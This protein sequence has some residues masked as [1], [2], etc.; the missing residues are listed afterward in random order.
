MSAF[1]KIQVGLDLATSATIVLAGL[2][3]YANKRRERKIGILNDARATVVEN[4]NA[5]IN[6]M[7]LEFNSFATAIISVESTIDRHLQRGE[8]HYKKAIAEKKIDIESIVQSFSKGVNDIGEFFEKASTLR[9]TIFPSLYSI[10]NQKDAVALLKSELNDVLCVYNESNAGYISL[11]AELKNLSEIIQS[12]KSQSDNQD[13]EELFKLVDAEY[14]KSIMSILL[15][16][17]YL[18]FIDAFIPK[19]FEQDYLQ[20]LDFSA[21]RNEDDI[22]K[23]NKLF[24]RV[25]SRFLMTIIDEPEETLAIYLNVL[26]R[27][28]LKARMQCKEL[29]VC[30]SAISCKMQQKS[31]NLSIREIYRDLSSN[32][33]LST[34]TEIR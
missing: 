16:R 17:D 19:G 8:E 34:E 27:Q 15:D 6:T 32:D 21:N 30:L 23:V 3:W 7:S 1:E 5:S 10:G 13:T 24:S 22:Q 20:A 12:I 28:M 14:E 4:I 2:T 26:S 18:F 33:Y 25:Y 11:Y 29:L 9:Y 31:D